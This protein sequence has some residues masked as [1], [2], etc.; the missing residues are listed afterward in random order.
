[1]T[2]ETVRLAAAV[3]DVA[4]S[5]AFRRMRQGDRVDIKKVLEDAQQHTELFL[6][7]V[8]LP[9]GVE[10]RDVRVDT[11]EDERQLH[12]LIQASVVPP[13]TSRAVTSTGYVKAQHHKEDFF[14]HQVEVHLADLERGGRDK[15]TLME[16]R[17]TLALF[18]GIVGNKPVS[19]LSADHCRAFFD[20]VVHWPR[21]ATKRQEFI[22]LGVRETIAKAK[23]LGE[24]PPAAATVEKHRQRLSTFIN[25]ARRNKLIAD[26]PLHGLV[27]Q[28]KD[29]T[30]D[31]TGRPFTQDE[32]NAIFEPNAFSVWSKGSAHR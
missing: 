9:N 11:P 17:H 4:L 2:K 21:H 18:R 15:K 28:K 19:E 1:M 3:L 10:L 23:A 13:N 29:V 30:Q 6:G 26:N 27:R 32:L 14:A 22:G 31:D 16:S 25:W 8:K 24:P 7:V 20:A 5:Q 12:S